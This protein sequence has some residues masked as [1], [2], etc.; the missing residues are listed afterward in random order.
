MIK[1]ILIYGGVLVAIGVFIWLSNFQAR[2]R[3]FIPLSY[4]V[5]LSVVLP[6]LLIVL[7]VFG[8]VF[9]VLLFLFLLVMAII[10]LL[11][12]LFGK[13]RFYFRKI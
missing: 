7:F 4:R 2:G 9:V 1:E 10:V 6:V 11:F 12:I 13:G 8:S 5:F 3:K